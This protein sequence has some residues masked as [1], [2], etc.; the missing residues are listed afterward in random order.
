MRKEQ[1]FEI[2]FTGHNVMSL[3]LVA[4][5]SGVEQKIDGKW[6]SDV[7]DMV[8]VPLAFAKTR[9]LARGMKQNPM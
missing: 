6:H 5:G 3:C 4:C 9:V 8:I 2:I 7:V 1:E